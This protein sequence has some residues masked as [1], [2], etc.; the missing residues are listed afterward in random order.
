MDSYEELLTDIHSEESTKLS[1]I[2][3]KKNLAFKVVLS[4]HG[5]NKADEA[6]Q[7]FEKTVQHQEIPKDILTFSVS[8]PIDVVNLLTT[9]TLVESKS[10]ARRLVEQGGVEVDG[11]KITDPHFIIEKKDGTIIKAGKRKYLKV[12]FTG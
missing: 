4:F 12:T 11:E 8:S 1:P 2:V 6:Q 10:E 3:R 7:I 9:S 5:K